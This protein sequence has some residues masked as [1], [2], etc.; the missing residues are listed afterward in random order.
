MTN[1]Q[2]GVDFLEREW[3]RIVEENICKSFNK[4]LVNNDNV[5]TIFLKTST[6]VLQNDPKKVITDINTENIVDKFNIDKQ[7]TIKNAIKKMIKKTSIEII[8]EREK[9]MREIAVVYVDGIIN[10]YFFTIRQNIKELSE[11]IKKNKYTNE[12][13]KKRIES[14]INHKKE[15]LKK[16]NI[17]EIRRKFI[18]MQESNQKSP[19]DGTDLKNILIVLNAR[20]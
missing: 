11:R 4:Y 3:S 1:I 12:D 5:K 6:A 15:I 10:N 2:G 18:E 16:K 7:P 9:S 17:I 19:V 8:N 14:E 13:E 20:K